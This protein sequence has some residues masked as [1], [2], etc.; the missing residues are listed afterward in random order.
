MEIS[1]AARLVFGKAGNA[2]PAQRKGWAAPDEG[3]TWSV[4][5]RADL[6]LTLAAGQG[7]LLIELVLRPFMHPPLLVRQKVQ[8]L[9]DEVPAGEAVVQDESAVSFRVPAAQLAGK[10]EIAVA[11]LCPQSV[12]PS[13]LGVSS[14][15][16]SLG[17]SFFELLAIWVPPEQP[18][19]PRHLPPLPRSSQPC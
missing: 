3:H 15:I 7:D 14:D 19:Y 13:D 5:P 11:L 10:R 4:G 8:V 9:V 6:I 18:V 12:C 16:R 1:T 2:A 17:F